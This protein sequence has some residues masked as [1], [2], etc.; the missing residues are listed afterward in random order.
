MLYFGWSL[1]GAGCAAQIQAASKSH[2]PECQ[3]DARKRLSDYLAYARQWPRHCHTCDAYGGR[4]TYGSRYEPPGFD[5]CCDCWAAMPIARCPRCAHAAVAWN[6]D[7]DD[8]D[9]PCDAC[10]WQ[11]ES[12]DGAP[13]SYNECPGD[14]VCLECGAPNG[15]DWNSHPFCSERCAQRAGGPMP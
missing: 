10:G 1:L 15:S 12:P 7:H 8:F 6:G 11:P 14:C 3:D 13:E 9:Q 4:A 2:S 5:E